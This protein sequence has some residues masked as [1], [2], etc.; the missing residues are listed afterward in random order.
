MTRP[1]V[2]LLLEQDFQ[3]TIDAL[4]EQLALK[5][6]IH[7]ENHRRS[8]ESAASLHP[9]LSSELQCARELAYLRGPPAG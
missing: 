7:H 4:N 5:Q 9:L 6:G 1:L 3:F 8:E 2:S